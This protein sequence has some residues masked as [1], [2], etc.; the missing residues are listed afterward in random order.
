VTL[1]AFA[2]TPAALADQLLA[3]VV[4]SEQPTLEQQRLQVRFEL[5]DV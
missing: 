1:V 2:L 4:N 5:I 3:V